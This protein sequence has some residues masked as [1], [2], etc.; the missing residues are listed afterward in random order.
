VWR[1]SAQ[2]W[3]T[4]LTAVALVGWAIV[5]LSTFLIDHFDLFGL[6]QVLAR[7]RG[8]QLAEHEFA[9]PLFYR[10][11]RHPNLLGFPDRV[12]GDTS[13][14]VGVLAFCGRDHGIHRARGAIGGA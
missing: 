11:V 6:R 10:V 7:L 4:L 9:T 5:L 8:R 3:R 2:P 12:L 1:V 13:N 14:D